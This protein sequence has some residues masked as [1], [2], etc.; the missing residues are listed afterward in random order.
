MTEDITEHDMT[1]Y[2]WSPFCPHREDG[3]VMLWDVRSAKS[4]LAVLDQHN[5][6]AAAEASSG[7]I[8]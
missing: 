6:E 1:R 3:R 4:S 2:S 8:T 7:N 5:G